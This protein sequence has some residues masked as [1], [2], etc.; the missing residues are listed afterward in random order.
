MLGFERITFNPDIMGG[1][2][3]IR[4]MNI[5]VSLIVNLIANGITFAE[6]LQAYPYLEE[7]DLQQSL[8]YVAWLADEFVYPMEAVAV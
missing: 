4:N 3:C 7:D 1:R 8:Q 5:S 6:V 2:A